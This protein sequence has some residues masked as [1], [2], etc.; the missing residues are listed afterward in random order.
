MFRRVALQKSSS[1]FGPGFWRQALR[2]ATALPVDR[3]AELAPPTSGLV[4][5]L[6]RRL[7]DSVPTSFNPILVSV[8]QWLLS[9]LWQ[10]LS[11]YNLQSMRTI[12]LLL[13]NAN[14]RPLPFWNAFIPR[15]STIVLREYENNRLKFLLNTAGR[16]IFSIKS[17]RV[18]SN[19]GSYE[20]VP[21]RSWRIL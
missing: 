7:P 1:A 19:E 12:F 6:C 3:L 15:V 4:S 16:M 2:A 5:E 11:I 14:W 17:G 10:V 21:L 20:S 18:M 8:S 9:M 13:S